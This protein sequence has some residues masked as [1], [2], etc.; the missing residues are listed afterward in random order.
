MSE[1]DPGH[2][3]R[4]PLARR[5]SEVSPTS[6]R[7]QSEGDDTAAIH[8]IPG[9]VL[10]RGVDSDALS[11]P[12]PR[13]FGRRGGAAWLNLRSDSFGSA[14]FGL[15]QLEKSWVSQTVP[16]LSRTTDMPM[17]VYEVLRMLAR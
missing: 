3:P 7:S 16:E 15:V 1:S 12:N 11:R 13:H 2:L 8:A 10:P 9:R 17:C 4:R 5:Q 6:V 14:W